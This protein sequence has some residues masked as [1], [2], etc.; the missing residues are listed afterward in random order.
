MNQQLLRSVLYMP[1]SNQRAMD[2]ARDLPCD[3]VV[4][5]LEDAVAPA[6]KVVAR[7]QVLAQIQAGGYGA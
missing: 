7:E 4:F 6:A 5:D 3:A 1:S 2:K